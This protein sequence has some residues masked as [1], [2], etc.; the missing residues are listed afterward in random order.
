QREHFRIR[1]ERHTKAPLVEVGNRGA[2][3]LTTAIARVL[4]RAR[5]GN[6]ASHLVDNDL[7]SW[8]V[9]VADAE[10]DDIESGRALFGNLLL[11]LGEQV[12]LQLFNA[13]GESMAHAV[14]VSLV[15]K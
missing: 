3:F 2:E 8:H 13:L 4:V 1:I 12:W 9:G 11:E 14:T 10:A 5:I 15:R 6:C 7:R